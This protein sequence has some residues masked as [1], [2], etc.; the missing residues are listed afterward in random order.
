MERSDLY[1]GRSYSLGKRSRIVEVEPY[2]SLYV[3]ATGVKVELDTPGD[4]IVET[5][6]G[7]NHLCEKTSLQADTACFQF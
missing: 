6:P 1:F 7:T 4:L 3:C 5:D 2:T